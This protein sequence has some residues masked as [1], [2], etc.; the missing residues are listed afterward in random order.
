MTT[1]DFDEWRRRYNR[2]S[3]A[4]QQAFY[5][6]L[7]QDHP[8]QNNYD[9]GAVQMALW[10]MKPGTKVLELGGWQGH[11][12][13]DLLAE[14]WAANI[15]EWTNVE[16]CREAVAASVC[17]D[18]RYRAISPPNFPWHWPGLPYPDVLVASH[19]FEHLRLSDIEALLQRAKPSRLVVTMPLPINPPRWE[20]EYAPHILEFGWQAFDRIMRRWKWE[21]LFS[22]WR[23]ER[24]PFPD[25]SVIYEHR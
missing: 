16:V 4:E 14:P 20:G 9:R 10:G 23:L 22:Q 18:P 17:T 1:S 3:W 21:I 7:W 13:A 12:A 15:S 11:L 5:S 8:D 25:R 24:R 19:V 2:M 6:R